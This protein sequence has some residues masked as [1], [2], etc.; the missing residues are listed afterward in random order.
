M[1]Q[2]APVLTAVSGAVGLAN[3]IKGQKSFSNDAKKKSKL[4]DQLTAEQL[5]QIRAL[6]PF[7]AQLQGSASSMLPM[8]TEDA[9]KAYE[10]AKQYDPATETERAMHD[11]DATA[12]DS[13][14]R[15][16]S[17]SVFSSRQR[18]FGAGNGSS[19]EKA[20]VQETLGRRARDRGT[21]LTNLRL[22]ERGKKEGAF[23]SASDR[24]SRAF[25]LSNPV[26][27]GTAIAGQLGG[28]ANTHYNNANNAYGMAAGFDP[29]GAIGAIGQGIGGI[30]WGKKKQSP[31]YQYT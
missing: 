29:S 31:A 5:E 14:N 21:M 8:I 9:T 7:M 23:A 15:D 1:A 4:G 6:K 18:G 19:D 30:K 26:A 28:V 27:P 20:M 3:Q 17:E 10:R 24:T 16:L 2:A 12:N 22:G 11:F 13:L 25:Q